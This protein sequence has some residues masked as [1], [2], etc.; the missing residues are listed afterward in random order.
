[1]S[2]LAGLAGALTDSGMF[3]MDVSNHT[4]RELEKRDGGKMHGY[5]TEYYKYLT[6]YDLEM[7]VLG[8]KRAQ[9]HEVVL[10]TWNAAL[11]VFDWMG[12][13]KTGFDTID[14]LIELE[15]VKGFPFKSV[16]TTRTEGAKK[17]RSATTIATT[18]VNHFEEMNVADSMFELH[19]DSQEI[20]LL[21]LGASQTQDSDDEPEEEKKVGLR[22]RLKRLRKGDG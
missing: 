14:I 18:K 1:M 16:T 20:A 15:K 7:K 22:E 4:V 21:G 2:A 13:R 17:K 19:P 6:E 8:M 3:D 5:D 9:H 12:P 11:D 10:E